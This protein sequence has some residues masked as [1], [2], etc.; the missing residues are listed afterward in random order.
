MFQ[1]VMSLIKEHQSRK[2]TRAGS[3]LK[4]KLQIQ[5]MDID[6]TNGSETQND[7]TKIHYDSDVEE[8][9]E[10][11]SP[12]DADAENTNNDQLANNV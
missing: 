12:Y 9:D 8:N 4:T 5:T 2:T 11:Q 6:H 1:V 7:D 3:L 10:N